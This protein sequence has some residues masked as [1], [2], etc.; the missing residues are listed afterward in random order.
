[1]KHKIYVRWIYRRK[2]PLATCTL[3]GCTPGEELPVPNAYTNSFE[4]ITKELVYALGTGSE[5]DNVLG[6]VRPSVCPSVRL[7]VWMSVCALTA[8]SNNSHYQS[9]V[10]VCVSVISGRRRIIAR[11]RSIGF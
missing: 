1:M 4:Q 8:K 9:K 6:S 2:A 5:G 3:K 11:M 10:F 7:S